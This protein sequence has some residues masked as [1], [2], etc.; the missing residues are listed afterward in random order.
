MKKHVATI[1]FQI[2]KKRGQKIKSKHVVPPLYQTFF[3]DFY[4][5]RKIF[6]IKFGSVMIF[7]EQHDCPKIF[8]Q[9]KNFQKSQ[10]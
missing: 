5:I 10:N 2:T 9:F 1:T 3:A 8:H 4:C 6:V 7:N